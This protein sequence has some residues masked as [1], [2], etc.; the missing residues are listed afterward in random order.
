MGPDYHASYMT[1]REY[2]LDAMYRTI[3]KEGGQRCSF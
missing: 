2:D 3:L 1:S